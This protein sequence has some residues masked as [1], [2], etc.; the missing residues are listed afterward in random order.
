MQ[1]AWLAGPPE[2]PHHPRDARGP[3]AIGADSAAVNAGGNHEG[4]NHEDR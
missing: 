3:Y 1:Q 2:A 4:E